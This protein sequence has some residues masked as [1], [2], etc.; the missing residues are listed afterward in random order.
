MEKT[1]EENS[2]GQTIDR[3]YAYIL[4]IAF[5]HVLDR[6]DAMDISQ[7]VFTRYIA[8]RESVRHDR[9][10]LIGTLK[11]VIKE[12]YRKIGNNNIPLD[13]S[14]SDTRFASEDKM[15]DARIIVRDIVE[16]T[17]ILS[18]K[19]KR[20]LFFRI[21]MDEDTIRS[22]GLELDYTENQARYWYGI[23]IKH[24]QQSFRTIGIKSPEDIL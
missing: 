10:W 19:R 13:D 9:L 1:K 3:Y 15:R 7:E 2:T 14:M 17:E 6:D 16:N 5:N 12:H 4:K 18:E 21:A 8:A 23:I 11:I 20:E 24:L 22:A